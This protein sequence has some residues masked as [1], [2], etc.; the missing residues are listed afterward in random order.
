MPTDAV[1]YLKS[2]QEKFKREGLDTPEERIERLTEG[3]NDLCE[4]MISLRK[5][6]GAVTSLTLISAL[7]NER[8]DKQVQKLLRK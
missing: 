4:G 2:T 8:T 3:L 5:Q 6:N 1:R 7:L